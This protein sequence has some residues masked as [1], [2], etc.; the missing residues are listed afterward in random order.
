MIN[1]TVTLQ[2]GC[3]YSMHRRDQLIS[4][5]A[6]NVPTLSID[7]RTDGGAPATVVVVEHCGYVLGR[8]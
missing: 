5:R 7:A 6:T 1:D 2:S 8:G 3:G 4:P